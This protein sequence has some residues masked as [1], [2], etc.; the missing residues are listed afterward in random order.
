MYHRAKRQGLLHR[1]RLRARLLPLAVGDVLPTAGALARML[2]INPSEAS[3]HLH[4]MLAE[5]GVATEVSGRGIRQRV[6]V[7]HV[8]DNNVL[9]DV[10]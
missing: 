2:G 1:Q 4:R 3:R 6:V 10:A 7:C 9:G 5:A 8:N